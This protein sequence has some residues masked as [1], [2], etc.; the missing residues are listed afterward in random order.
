MLILTSIKT[1]AGHRSSSNAIEKRLKDAGYDTRQLDVFPLMG[2][3]G[4]FM[5][6]SYIPLTTKA[7][8]AYYLMERGSEHF[9][10]V[11]HSQMYYRVR[12]QLLKKIKE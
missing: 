8:Y 7:P 9:P 4:R 11:V 10:F 3:L 6:N 12:K 2:R 5:E 1:G